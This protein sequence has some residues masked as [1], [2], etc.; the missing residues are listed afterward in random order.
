MHALSIDATNGPCRPIRVL[1][2]T[3]TTPELPSTCHR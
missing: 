1:A 3:M 2:M